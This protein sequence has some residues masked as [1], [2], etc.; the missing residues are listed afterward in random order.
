[1]SLA[2]NRGLRRFAS[3]EESARLSNGA[4]CA[5]NRAACLQPPLRAR[6]HPSSRSAFV[7]RIIG[8]LDSL[9]VTVSS[10]R[11]QVASWAIM[12]RRITRRRTI[13]VRR[14]KLCG[15]IKRQVGHQ[16][17]LASLKASV[18]HRLPSSPVGSRRDRRCRK[19]D[20]HSEIQKSCELESS[21]QGAGF[22]DSQAGIS[23]IDCGYLGG[24]L[25]HGS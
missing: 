14:S 1:M 2:A 6:G 12:R 22:G 13:N 19:Y 11:R 5:S 17:S 18:L 4:G 8:V 21:C 10:E 23:I 25:W 15:S 9:P 3:A 7:A 24:A 16:R 20:A